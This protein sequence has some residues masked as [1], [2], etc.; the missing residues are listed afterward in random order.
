VPEENRWDLTS[1]GETVYEDPYVAIYDY[2][3]LLIADWE[4]AAYAL[5]FID[6][7]VGE[8][9]SYPRFPCYDC[10]GSRPYSS[11]DPYNYVCTDFRV[12]LWDDPYYHPAYRYTGTRVVFP[13]S[14]QARPRYTLAACAPGEGWL[15]VKERDVASAPRSAEPRRCPATSTSPSAS[16]SRKCTS[17]PAA[18]PTGDR[19]TS[20]RAPGQ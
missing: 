10:H 16:P 9:H 1:V 14:L 4:V 5:D 2:V 6:Y 12:V 8:A 3:A 13:R 7:S 19:H 18:S 17:Y 11:W 20:H 15:Q